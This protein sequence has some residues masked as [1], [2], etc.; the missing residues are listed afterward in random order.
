MVPGHNRQTYDLTLVAQIKRIV[1]FLCN[2]IKFCSAVLIFGSR[3][4]VPNLGSMYP[5]GYIC[6]SEGVHLRLAIQ[7]KY[8]FTYLLFPNI[9]AYIREYYS[10][11]L[12]YA[13]C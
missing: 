2:K 4:E 10:Q 5:W 12:L 13:Y 11:K 9:Y 7:V 1:F 8:I 6:L 3:A